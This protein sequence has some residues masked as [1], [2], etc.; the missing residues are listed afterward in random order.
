MMNQIVGIDEDKINKP[1]RPLASGLINLNQAKMR[2]GITMVLFPTYAY[3]SGD[4]TILCSA[5]GWQVI[6]I[7]YN[8]FGFDKHWFN[9]NIV[10]I[11]TGT[12]VQL[13]A[14]YEYGNLPLNVKE[15]DLPYLWILYIS[16]AFGIS[17]NLQ[18][19]RD[20]IGD[21]KLNRQTLPVLL[22]QEKSRKVIA[23]IILCLPISLYIIWRIMLEMIFVHYLLQAVLIAFN[24]YVALKVIFGDKYAEKDQIKGLRQEDDH[25]IYMVHCYYFCVLIATTLFI[26]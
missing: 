20:V 7:C 12:F 5:I 14:A 3:F 18:D 10:F 17:L 1:D 23:F 4:L 2:L 15:R 19:L 16:L 26:F 24:L 11:T 13:T 21:Q 9:K 6:M 25:S 22:G 8:Y